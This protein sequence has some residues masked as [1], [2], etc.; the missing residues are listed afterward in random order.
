M[1]SSINSAV[2][3]PPPPPRS[4]PKL[5]DDQQTLISDTLSEFDVD[6]LTEEDAISI[7]EIFSEAGIQPGKEMEAAFSELGFDAKNIG[8]LA[9]LE[10]G[11]RGAPPPPPATQDSGE[12]SS[13][14][15]YLGELLDEKLAASDEAELSE[16]DREDIYAQVMQKFGIEEG[17]SIISTMV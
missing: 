4:E 5:T 13:M 1:I 17:E 6:N 2:A 16:Q 14:V 10:E 11:S 12:I 3:M 9:N 7:V 15:S 8:D